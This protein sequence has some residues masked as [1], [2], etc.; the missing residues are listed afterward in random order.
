MALT[1]RQIEVVNQLE[2]LV[3]SRYSIETLNTKL[4]EIFNEKISVEDCTNLDNEPCDYDLM[5]NSENEET[6]GYFDIYFLKMINKG[7]D[8]A[9]MYITEIAY[10]FD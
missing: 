7:F 4:S 8:G 3:G 6:Y 2:S 5:F 10:E 1:D 9:D